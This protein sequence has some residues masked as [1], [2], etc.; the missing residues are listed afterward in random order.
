M[1]DKA[2][3]RVAE[4]E[5]ISK[6]DQ[7][8]AKMGRDTLADVDENEAVA[9]NIPP[10]GQK[11][12]LTGGGVS[13]K[14]E[15]TENLHRDVKQG[16]NTKKANDDDIAT[17]EAEHEGTVSDEER[18]AALREYED[19]ED[20]EG[21]GFD[22]ARYVSASQMPPRM[23]PDEG[24]EVEEEDEAIS[25]PALPEDFDVAGLVEGPGNEQMGELYELVRT[26]GCQKHPEKTDKCKRFWEVNDPAAMNAFP[27]KRLAVMQ[28]EA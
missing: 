18:E 13:F 20:E 14:G 2:L 25:P 1:L 7:A 17:R 4:M 9:G 16:S 10:R 28:V 27:N 6:A 3:Y 22:L 5:D 21:G 23:I 12:T 8:A 15:S 24:D 26:C 11:G 19:D